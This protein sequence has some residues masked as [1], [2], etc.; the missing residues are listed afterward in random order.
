MKT[1]NLQTQAQQ[2]PN[3]RNLKKTTI[4]KLLK[5]SEKE[6]FQKEPENSQNIE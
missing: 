2:T 6:K 1:T 3:T 4:F 5:T